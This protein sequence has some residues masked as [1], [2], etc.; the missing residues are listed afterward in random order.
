[1]HNIHVL[2]SN[3][4]HD[5]TTTKDVSGRIKTNAQCSHRFL[6]TGCTCPIHKTSIS[7]NRP[8]LNPSF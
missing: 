1:V 6:H 8:N 2:L 4:L 5:S 3:Q 7:T